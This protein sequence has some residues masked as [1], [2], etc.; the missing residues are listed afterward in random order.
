MLF[1]SLYHSVDFSVAGDLNAQPDNGRAGRCSMLRLETLYSTQNWHDIPCAA[2]LTSIYMCSKV[3]SIGKHL[4]IFSKHCKLMHSQNLYDR[5]NVLLFVKWWGT[6]LL[7]KTN[8]ILLLI[9]L[10]FHKHVLNRKVTFNFPYRML[11]LI[12]QTSW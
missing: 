9:K 11:K 12:I 7:K 2:I 8:V 4:F 1:C 6:I 3:S 5:R 10:D